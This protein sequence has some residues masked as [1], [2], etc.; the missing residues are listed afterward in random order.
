MSLRK[1]G[2]FNT[3]N[4]ILFIIDDKNLIYDTII[5]VGIFFLSF[6]L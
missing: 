4:S 1:V 6:V 3:D 5:I 2:R